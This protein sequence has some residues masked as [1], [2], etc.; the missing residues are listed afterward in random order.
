MVLYGG[1]DG[2]LSGWDLNSQDVII[3]TK[4]DLENKCN[5]VSS[6]DYDINNDLVAASGNFK[7]VYINKISN[8]VK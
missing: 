7:G 3:D 8:L 5:L 6:I 2:R 4:L 1:E